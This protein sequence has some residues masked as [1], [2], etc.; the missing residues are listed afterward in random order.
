MLITLL[1]MKQIMP[2]ILDNFDQYKKYQAKMKASNFMALRIKYVWRHKQDKLLGDHKK[3]LHNRIRQV[4]TVVSFRHDSL[5]D[6][7]KSVI[8]SYLR[9]QLMITTV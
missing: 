3:R 6:Q 5:V 8:V 4:L 2:K 9:K 1:K 7:A